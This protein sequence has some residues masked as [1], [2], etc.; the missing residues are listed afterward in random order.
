[1]ARIDTMLAKAD[2][3]GDEIKL[4]A[5]KTDTVALADLRR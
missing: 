4:A 2:P 3:A 5:A 1:M